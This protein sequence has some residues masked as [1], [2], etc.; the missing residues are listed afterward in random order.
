M[1]FKNFCKPNKIWVD[2]RSEYCNKSIKLWL[3]S[4]DK[5]MYST[6]NK[7]KSV[8]AKRSIRTLKNKIYKC[9]TK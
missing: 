3:Q 9:I 7:G 8:I 2:K 6:H 1:I 4:N 5:E